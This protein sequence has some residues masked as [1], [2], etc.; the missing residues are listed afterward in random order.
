MPCAE[1]VVSLLFSHILLIYRYTGRL[2]ALMKRNADGSKLDEE[3]NIVDFTLISFKSRDARFRS[4]RQM[5][6]LSP[7]NTMLTNLTGVLV[8]TGT[9]RAMGAFEAMTGTVR[10]L[11]NYLLPGNPEFMMAGVLFSNSPYADI[12]PHKLDLDAVQRIDDPSCVITYERDVFPG[13]RRRRIGQKGVALLFESGRFV[14][15]GRPTESTMKESVDEVRAFIAAH[16]ETHVPLDTEGML[17]RA[18]VEAT[19]RDKKA[20]GKL[21]ARSRRDMVSIGK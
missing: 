19:A 15:V 13:V 6:P 2:Y 7:C 17:A 16:P 1:Q 4:Q 11:K 12:F 21:R 5:V 8:S 9:D 3:N 18:Q 14:L 20:T 10:I